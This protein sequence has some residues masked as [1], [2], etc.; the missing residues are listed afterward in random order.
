[1]L[2]LP[3]DLSAPGASASSSNTCCSRLRLLCW[4]IFLQVPALPSMSDLSCVRAPQGAFLSSLCPYLILPISWSCGSVLLNVV[5]PS[6]SYKAQEVPLSSDQSQWEDVPRTVWGADRARRQPRI[7]EE[8]NDCREAS[9]VWIR[10][11][12]HTGPQVLPLRCTRPRH[13][14]AGAWIWALP[15]QPYRKTCIPLIVAQHFSSAT[16]I[17]CLCF[18]RF[19]RLASFCH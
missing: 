6:K 14:G 13:A 7:C 3:Y 2:L 8:G 9:L 17:N 4:R 1:M 5:G 15:P 12:F 11:C 10:F 19:Y 16:R 18:A